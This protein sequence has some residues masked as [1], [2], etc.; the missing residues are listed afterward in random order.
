MNFNCKNDNRNLKVRGTVL[1]VIIF[2]LTAESAMVFNKVKYSPNDVY[3]NNEPGFYTKDCSLVGFTTC[4]SAV[5]TGILGY[6]F[7]F[8]GTGYNRIGDN[9]QLYSLSDE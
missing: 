6:Y 5:S 9:V 4:S 8:D 3:Y 7:T 1:L 2:G